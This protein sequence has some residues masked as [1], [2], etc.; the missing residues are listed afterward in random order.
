MGHDPK[1]GHRE[2]S[3]GMVVGKT[4]FEDSFII[5][6][7]VFI[8]SGQRKCEKGALGVSPALYKYCHF[9]AISVKSHKRVHAVTQT[10]L[11]L[12]HCHFANAG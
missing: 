11:L 7:S 2:I 12:K 4:P 1:M 6:S 5:F 8:L 9:H 3:G 10:L